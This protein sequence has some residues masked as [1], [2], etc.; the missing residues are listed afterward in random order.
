MAEEFNPTEE[1]QRVAREYL[2]K[3]GW[4]REWRRALN[5]QLYPAVDR[6]EFE[7]KQRQC[8]QREEAAEEDFSR[9]IERWR[10]DPSPQA[11]E[12]L[13]TIYE[14]LGKRSDLGFFGKRIMEHLKR[15]FT[16]L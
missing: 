1:G 7:A 12:V 8:D 14:M 3:L 11:K 6:E 13:R 9:N 4:A 16:P 5:R 10:H 15:M 2:S